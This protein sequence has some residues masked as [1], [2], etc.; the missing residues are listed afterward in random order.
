[1]LLVV[2]AFLWCIVVDLNIIL[3][4]C[5]L[6]LFFPSVFANSWII[7]IVAVVAGIIIWQ[8]VAHT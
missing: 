3:F 4:E 1:V 8:I 6:N 5:Q 2:A 7:I